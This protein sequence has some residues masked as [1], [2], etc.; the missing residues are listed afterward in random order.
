M[1][2]CGWAFTVQFMRF[3]S[4]VEEIFAVEVR[5]GGNLGRRSEELSRHV[6]LV[7]ATAFSVQVL[8]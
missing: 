1:A 7:A 3:E 4:A 6:E 2:I 8:Q 5:E